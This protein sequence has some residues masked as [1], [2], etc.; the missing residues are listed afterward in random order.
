MDQE[1]R[2]FE[3]P[4]YLAK[5]NID[6]DDSLQREKRTMTVEN[7]AFLTRENEIYL[8]QLVDDFVRDVKERITMHFRNLANGRIIPDRLEEEVWQYL[9]CKQFCVVFFFLSQSIR[10][11]SMSASH[12]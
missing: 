4:Y 12:F 2:L 3:D 9:S 5:Y 8:S 11:R 1:G 10:C 6:M 7:D